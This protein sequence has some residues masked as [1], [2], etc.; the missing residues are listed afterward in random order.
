VVRPER[1]RLVPNFR[2]QGTHGVKLLLQDKGTNEEVEPRNRHT[3]K[4]HTA[5][6]RSRFM[7]A[8]ANNERSVHHKAPHFGKMWGIAPRSWKFHGCTSTSLRP[9]AALAFVTRDPTDCIGV[10]P[11]WHWRGTDQEVRHVM[12]THAGNGQRLR[13]ITKR[14]PKSCGAELAARHD[15]IRPRK[16]S[17]DVSSEVRSCGRQSLQDG[18]LCE[19]RTDRYKHQRRVVAGID[20][21]K[22]SFPFRFVVL[23]SDNL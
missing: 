17:R 12:Y 21:M 16:A 8:L 15:A 23:L 10:E 19:R 22:A 18:R 20:A 9:A 3:H 6:V 7:L 4:S 2:D 5:K 1:I 11:G 14:L 13:R